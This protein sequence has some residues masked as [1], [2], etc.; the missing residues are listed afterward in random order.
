MRIATHDT[1]MTSLDFTAALQQEFIRWPE[2][3]QVAAL[4]LLIGNPYVTVIN[5]SGL[6][7]PDAGASALAAALHADAGGRV[8]VLNLERNDLREPGLLNI[9]GALQSNTT[10]REL[11]LTDQRTA[12]STAVEMAL[13][14]MLDKALATAAALSSLKIVASPV[15]HNL[16]H[17][18]T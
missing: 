11:R 14:E 10:L 5:L 15:A 12:V 17:A 13:A 6:T 3:R 9:V 18:V 4:A 7:L 16:V 2:P 8:E 1:S